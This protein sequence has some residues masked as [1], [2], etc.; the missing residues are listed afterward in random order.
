[1]DED[2]AIERV[3]R[4]DVEAFRVLVGRH[5]RTLFALARCHLRE[6]TQVE[7]VVQES[8]VRAFEAL[9]TFDPRR[10]TFV[11]WLHAIGRNLCRDALRRAARRPDPRRAPPAP[12]RA[13]DEVEA[14][15]ELGPRLDAALE[16]LPPERR[17][18]FLLLEVH[19]LSVAEAA[20]I[21]Q[22]APGTIKSRA[23]RAR[24]SLR[25]AL[26]SR[27]EAES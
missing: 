17:V 5:Q 18:A 4:G 10:G 6:E 7:D 9:E 19:G 2:E 11:A 8:F 16:A 22:V 24:A 23:A 26:G 12:P 14:R 3:R 27:Q 25:A 21:E 13:G 20:E 15:D 1:M